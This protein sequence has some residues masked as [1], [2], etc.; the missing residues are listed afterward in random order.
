MPARSADSIV[1]RAAAVAEIRFVASPHRGSSSC[2]SAV[3]PS[4][5]AVLV[6]HAEHERVAAAKGVLRHA[7][8]AEPSTEAIGVSPSDL[9]HVA[10][11]AALRVA[12]FAVQPLLIRHLLRQLADRFAGLVERRG[13]QRVARRAEL[14]P[15]DVR[16]SRR[17]EA[18]R[19]AHDRLSAR[20]RPSYGP[21]SGR[22]PRLVRA[23]SKPP[24]KLACSPRFVGGDLMADGARHAVDARAHAR[25]VGARFANTSPRSPPAAESKRAIG[26]WQVE[27]LSSIAACAPG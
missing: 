24:S 19:R 3:T 23:I 10:A 18:R 14:R 2:G 22:A 15:L 11:L 20:D 7:A 1:T 9:G 27:H 6:Q 16:A 21:N 5:A 17:H 4:S 13:E 12:I 25:R 26:M 8:A